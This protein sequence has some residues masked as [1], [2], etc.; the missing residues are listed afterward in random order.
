MD[1]MSS[2]PVRNNLK[3]RG[4]TLIE[5]MIT[6]VILAVTATMATPAMQRLLQGNR[7][8][9][10]TTRLL[11]AVNLARSE[12]VMRNT[13]VSLCPSVMASSGIPACTSSY[14]QGWMV[15][16]NRD[17]DSVFDADSDEVIRAFG[18]IPAGYSLTNM[19]GTRPAGDLITYLPDGSSRLNRSLLFCP[20]ASRMVEPRA[21]VINRVGRARI[22][23]GEGLCP[24][25]AP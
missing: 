24:G 25:S 11:D 3:Y 15:F 8:R 13:P 5:L 7:L 18:A 1:R 14:A 10:E 22:S 6:L 20:P 23:V 12:A 16:A 17:R 21:V 19:A 4:L 9:T 2:E